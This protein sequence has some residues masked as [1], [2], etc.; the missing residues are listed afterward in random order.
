M[1]E[2]YFG[3]GNFLYKTARVK[4]ALDAHLNALNICLENYGEKHSLVALSWKQLAD[5]YIDQTEYLTGLECY[6]KALI[7]IDPAFNNNDIFTNPV[8]DSSLFDIR[9]LDIL[10]NKSKAFELY[11]GSEKEEE[12]KLKL[13]NAGLSTV[14]L[15]FH[16]TDRIRKQLP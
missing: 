11:A 2:V 3:Y 12:L 4:E 13:L 16:L 8:I 10:K 5:Y 1:S 9:L 14:N 7:A 15:A 6:Q